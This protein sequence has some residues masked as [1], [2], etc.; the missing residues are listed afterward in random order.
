MK[1]IPD[2]FRNRH[3]EIPWKHMARMRDKLIHDYFG[4][5]ID[6]VWGVA[7]EDLPKLI[8]KLEHTI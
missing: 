3:S 5:N 6:I 7:T 8:E 1:N 4:I 2:E